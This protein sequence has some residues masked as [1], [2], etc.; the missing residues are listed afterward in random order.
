MTYLETWATEF[1]AHL[2]RWRAYRATFAELDAMTDRQLTDLG[3]S[4]LALQ[5]VAWSASEQAALRA[6]GSG[7]KGRAASVPA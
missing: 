6:S 4:R 1:R 3:F 7:W 5:D 2:A